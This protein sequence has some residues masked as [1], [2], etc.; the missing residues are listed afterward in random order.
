VSVP[1]EP[2]E[3]IVH[4]TDDRAVV[5]GPPAETKDSRRGRQI[6][7]LADGEWA[8]V[9]RT[10]DPATRALVESRRLT[11]S[12]VELDE[13]TRAMWPTARKIFEEN[14][15]V[16][17]NLRDD[18]GK[19]SRLMRIRPAS[20]VA[21]LAGGAAVL[22]A[23]AAQAQAAQMAADIHA[24]R[25]RL[26]D[27]YKHLQND[28]IGAAENV[29]EQ[30]SGLV[31]RLREHGVDGVDPSEFA[32]IRNSLG[33]ARHKCLRHLGDSVVRLESTELG[34]PRKAQKGLPDHT[35]QEVMLYL[36]LL[37]KI[38][39]DTVRFELAQVAFYYHSGKIDLARTW[40]TRTTQAQA[41]LRAEI[42]N[43][44][45][46]IELLDASIRGLFQPTTEH[47]LGW[48]QKEHLSKAA[49]AYA[50]MSQVVNGKTVKIPGVPFRIPVA[51]ATAAGVTALAVGTGAINAVVQ[52]R[53][54]KKLDQRL[55]RLEE[56]GR[57]SLQT[58][59]RAA[60]NLAILATL[61]DELAVPGE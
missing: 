58:V 56:A 54:Q 49:S 31:L 47:A 37:G 20:G 1:D 52:P 27:L 32:V 6:A 40:S 50:T 17:A 11:G 5:I 29:A 41:Q 57:R 10:L 60:P 7:E 28:R 2:Q 55:R 21:A 22:S 3:I 24:I 18:K 51:G 23:V 16:Q 61:V 43:A 14:G 25:I 19:I 4:I 9:L 13:T 36:D 46:R 42:E 26:T 30:I 53:A 38:H 59:D 35:V 33:D 12:L 44:C 8:A 34:S 39:F 45:A 15:W 48:A